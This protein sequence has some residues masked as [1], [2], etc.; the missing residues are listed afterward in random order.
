M[1]LLLQA[2]ELN[3]DTDYYINASFLYHFEYIRESS[4]YPATEISGHE[5]AKF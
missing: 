1:E 2:I 3:M 4:M 5:F